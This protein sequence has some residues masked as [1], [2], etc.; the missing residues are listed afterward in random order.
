V[1]KRPNC[2]WPGYFLSWSKEIFFWPTG[3]NIEKFDIFRGNFPKSNPNHKWL[4]RPDP[5]QATKNWPDP[6]LA[7]WDDRIWFIPISMKRLYLYLI[8]IKTHY[9][10]WINYTQ[11]AKPFL[12]VP[13]GDLRLPK[14]L[15]WWGKLGFYRY[16]C[17]CPTKPKYL[18]S[19]VDML[20]RCS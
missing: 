18:I 1:N 13:A 17:Q 3:K 5:S 15:R 11:V 12:G 2:L 19:L 7:V 6:S 10:S 8:K 16:W 14:W 4:T 20:Y 9:E